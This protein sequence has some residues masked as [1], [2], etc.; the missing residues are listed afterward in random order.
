MTDDMDRVM[1]KMKKLGITIT[2]T[3]GAGVPEDSDVRSVSDLI[4][5]RAREHGIS[6]E[7]TK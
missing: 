6:E 4:G 1:R 7:G 5:E 3:R 2:T